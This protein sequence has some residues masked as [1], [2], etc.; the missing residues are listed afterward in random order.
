MTCPEGHICPARP[1]S[2]LDDEAAISASCS[3]SARICAF[4]GTIT[5]LSGHR[6]SGL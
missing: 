1:R 4:L 3:R 6:R 2:L 5:A